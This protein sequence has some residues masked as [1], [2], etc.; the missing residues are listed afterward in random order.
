M[1][2]FILFFIYIKVLCKEK[3]N[4]R[5]KVLSFLKHHKYS[6]FLYL[7]NFLNSFNISKFF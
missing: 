1:F 2:K 4:A 6:Q 7:L 5:Q 3:T